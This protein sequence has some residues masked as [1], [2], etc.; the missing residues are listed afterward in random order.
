MFASTYWASPSHDIFLSLA[1]GV[2]HVWRA[3]L[4]DSP[5]QASQYLPYLSTDERARAERFRVPQPQY[6]FVSTRGILRRLLSRYSGVTAAKLQFESNTQGK[7]RLPDPSLSHLQFNVSH[8]TGMALLAV[9]V[10]HAV[11]IDVERI[12]RAVS[13]HDIAARYFSPSESAYLASLS[14]D[15]RTREFLTYWTCKEA[16]LKMRGIGLS[17]GLAQCEIALDPDGVKAGV[18]LT[19]EPG[20]N[21]ECSLFRVNAGQT[22]VGALAVEWPSVEVSFW[23]WRD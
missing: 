3:H 19:D 9:T 15:H 8:T 11:G 17:G 23:D 10:E 13:D 22:H 2:V 1:P 16:Y 21:N 6:E 5:L 12:N 20:R 14:P 18:S 7:P 4:E